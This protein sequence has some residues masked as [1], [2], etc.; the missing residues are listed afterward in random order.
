MAEQKRTGPREAGP[1]DHHGSGI[2]SDHIADDRPAAWLSLPHSQTWLELVKADQVPDYMMTDAIHEAMTAWAREQKARRERPAPTSNPA[3]GRVIYGPGAR[4][5]AERRA[6]REAADTRTPTEKYKDGHDATTAWELARAW[7]NWPTVDAYVLGAPCWKCDAL[8]GAPCTGKLAGA[9]IFHAVRAKFGQACRDSD[10]GEYPA[11][12]SDIPGRIKGRFAEPT[13]VDQPAEPPAEPLPVSP[14]GDTEPAEQPAEL[15]PYATSAVDVWEKGYSPLPL[16]ARDKAEPPTGYTGHAGPMLSRADVQA[17]LDDPKYAQANIGIRLPDDVLGLDVDNY[18]D[19]PGKE[20]LADRENRWGALPLTPISTSRT[21]GISGIRLYRVPPGLR[22]VSG[23]PGIE[24]IAH[25]HR[26]CV[27]APS[28]HPEGRVYRWDTDDGKAPAVADLPELPAAWVAGLLRAGAADTARAELPDGLQAY[29]E[30]MIGAA[31]NPCPVMLSAL[32]AALSTPDGSRYDHQRDHSIALVRKAE[33]GHPGILAALAVHRAHY[34]ESVAD[35]RPE[36]DAIEEFMRALTGACEKV[37]ATPS[38]WPWA[39]QDP[40]IVMSDPPHHPG[41]P[42]PPRSGAAPADHARAGDSKLPPAADPAAGKPAAG[43]KSNGRAVQITWA[44]TIEAEPV[45]WVWIE[46]DNERIPSGS[47]ILDAG[48]E[49]TGK[50]SFGI[51]KSARVST[52]TLPGAYYGKPRRVFYVAVEDSWRHTIVPRLLAAGADLTMIGR[53]EVAVDTDDDGAVTLSLPQD[54]P[55]LERSI[56]EHDVALVV[57]DPLMSVMGDDIDTH[58][59]REVRKALEPLVRIAERTGVVIEGIAH[60]NKGSGSDAASLITGSGA[61]KDVPRAIF[62]FVSDGDGGRVMSQVKNSL[63]RSDLPSLSYRMDQAIVPTKK[64]PAKTGKFVFTGTSDR[65]VDQILRDGRSGDDDEPKGDGSSLAGWIRAYLRG[66]GGSAPANEVIDAGVALSFSADAVKSARSKAKKP[67]IMSAKSGF[68]GIWVWSLPDEDVAEGGSK[69]AEGITH[70]NQPPMT[71]SAPCL[72]PWDLPDA[73]SRRITEPDTEP[74]PRG[75]KGVG[76]PEWSWQTLGML[77]RSVASIG[78]GWRH[79]GEIVGELASADAWTAIGYSSFDEMCVDQLGIT[80]D[81][82]LG[83]LPA[84]KGVI[85]SKIE[86]VRKLTPSGDT[87]DDPATSADPGPLL[88]LCGCGRVAE[89][90]SKLC[91]ACGA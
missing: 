46:D 56:I 9:A 44:S 32:G 43:G 73:A 45:V 16:P 14:I 78:Q 65:S 58:R 40:C 42:I 5:F 87:F 19:K 7:A 15:Y 74:G 1:G 20:T 59:N 33:Q 51:W 89:P 63:G 69:V 67:R 22:Y 47:L 38:P 50:S 4:E 81:G 86:E 64:G 70:T 17:F 57:I 27:G 90:E 72:P 62:G 26:Y 91:E 36:T 13:T 2:E 77:R 41:D 34:I 60:F 83:H 84:I 80:G 48:R 49:G 61:F 53:L 29:L 76:S 52:G 25:Y 24:L 3:V 10:K 37:K 18:E 23:L 66:R 8:R 31:E 75:L 71:P 79:A 12:G 68:G 88:E 39:K 30:E 28:I 85:G 21:D 54:I 82:I 55:A 35:T 11:R 6:T